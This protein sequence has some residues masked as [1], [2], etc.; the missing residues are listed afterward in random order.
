M[1]FHTLVPCL[2]V[3]L[4]FTGCDRLLSPEGR[5]ER[6]QSAFEAGRDAD[7]MADVKAALEREP[8]NVEGRVLLARLSLR[9]GD[10]PTARKEL[11][12]AVEAGAPREA[13]RDTDRAILLAQERYTEALDAAD[14]DS[15]SDPQRLLDRAAALM[16]LGRRDA[17]REAIDAA[18][19]TAPQD[20][21]ARLADARW[22]WASG[23][24]SEATAALDRLLEAEPDFALAGL[25]RG[26]Y[27]LSLG[28]AA[29]AREAFEIARRQ[30]QRQLSQPEQ[31]GVLVGLV[32]SALALGDTQR[33]GADLVTLSQRAP[34][35]F[36]TRYLKARVAYASRDFD[37]AAAE[38]QRA[39]AVVPDSA[40]A[41]LLLAAVL[42]EQGS[43]E[44]ARA[45]LTRILAD[46][47]GN[48]EARKQLARVLLLGKD[49]VAARRVL[50]EV[51]AGSVP[52]ASLDWMSGSIAL[53]S[54]D[55]EE[56]IGKLEEGS[57]A[58]P[59]NV[60]LRLDLARAYLAVGRR[61]D[62]L[63]TLRAVPEAA[64]GA[65]RSQLLVLAEVAGKDP[66]TARQAIGR[67][68]QDNPDDAGLKVVAGFYLLVN[69]Q[70]AAASELFDAAMRLEP[71]NVDARLGA[72]AADLQAGRTAEADA[73]FREVLNIEPANERAHVG[74]A[75]IALA[76]S[77]RAAAAQWLERAIGANP[78]VVESRLRLAELAFADRDPV[79]GNALLDQALAVT[80]SRAATLNRAGQ[81]LLRSSQFDGALRRFNEAA[82]LGNEQAGV[83]AALAQ[84]ALGRADDA[85]ARLEAAV[86]NRPAW[87]APTALLVQL[88]STQ[89]RFDGALERIA[90]FEK[91][92][93]A[94][95]LASEWRGDVYAAA[96]QSARAADA[97]AQAAQVAPSAALAIKG[98]RAASAARQGRPEARL[99]EWLRTHPADP[100][101]RLSLAEYRQR[102]GDR[103][104]AIADYEQA[105]RVWPGPAALNNLA[106]LYFEVGDPRAL[107]LAR[108]AHAGAAENADISDTYGWILLERGKIDEALP[109]L[110]AAAKSA[111]GA[112]EIQYHYAA[113]LARSG[114]KEAAATVL[115]RVIHENANFPARGEAEALL[116]SLEEKGPVDQ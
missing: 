95:A 84:I 100:M 60:G 113:A 97:Y 16:G 25:Y 110:E 9:L 71:R 46:Q 90:A 12:R 48:V 6:A 91:A 53:L 102:Q 112:A 69:G 92:G 38:L 61:D 17:A 14:S 13:V 86:R 35:A 40:P 56:G 88:D 108:R 79:K 44:Q 37:T 81:V 99:T 76:K 73:A 43:L 80:T 10:V 103:A 19:Q 87:A 83:S 29:R 93:G 72:A 111:P 41:R 31:F 59:D 115:K 32:E 45:E 28:D 109:V 68:V 65:R 96:G 107:E 89:K 78:S 104:G 39:L 30:G 70:G 74:L 5:I 106:W 20:R 21:E 67:L 50:A 62:A 98:F 49:P 11:D 36:P 57:A 105:I 75:M 8:G 58:A 22:L 114:K 52:D 24:T 15:G 3:A 85:R 55:T 2:L 1:R 7:A 4:A 101:V 47:P 51:P 18:L 23:R 94:S 82:A 34:E 54:G 63:A 116:E 42:T 26:R 77:D 27:A 66:A 64:G 33:A